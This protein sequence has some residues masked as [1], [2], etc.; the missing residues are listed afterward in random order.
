MSLLDIA[1]LTITFPVAGRG[2]EVVRSVS[3]SV[4][5]GEMVGLVGESGSGKTMTALA[6]MRLVPAPGAITRGAIRFDGRN[7]L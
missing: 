1:D 6:I 4:D 7:L 2:V 5:A 3:F